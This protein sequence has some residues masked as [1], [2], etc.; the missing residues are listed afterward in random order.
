LFELNLGNGVI[1]GAH[2]SDA[3]VV[4]FESLSPD[5]LA[6]CVALNRATNSSSAGPG[7]HRSDRANKHCTNT[8]TES[9][10]QGIRQSANTKRNM[11][12]H[13]RRPC[14]LLGHFGIALWRTVL[15]SYL[16]RA[17]IDR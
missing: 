7:A 10:L 9:L 11:N 8:K 16:R 4:K 17:N 6:Q 14:N 15:G 3:L 13:S 2:E 5:L 12:Y 1:L